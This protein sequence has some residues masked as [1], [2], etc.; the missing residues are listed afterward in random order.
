[1]WSSHG[2]SS[3]EAAQV[4]YSVRIIDRLHGV[5]T[6]LSLIERI[7]IFAVFSILLR[8][9]GQIT[10]DVDIRIQVN[11]S[12]SIASNVTS[13]EIKRKKACIRGTVPYQVQGNLCPLSGMIDIDSSTD[14]V[15]T[16]C[17]DKGREEG[18]IWM[19]LCKFAD[20]WSFW[21]VWP[22]YRILLIKKTRYINS[23]LFLK[24]FIVSWNGVL[25][26]WIFL[27]PRCEEHWTGQWAKKANNYITCFWNTFENVQGSWIFWGVIIEN[28]W[29]I[30]LPL[31]PHA[32]FRS[33]PSPTIHQIC[34][35]SFHPAIIV[36][37]VHLHIWKNLVSTASF[38]NLNIVHIYSVFVN[39]LLHYIYSSFHCLFFTSY[40]PL[41]P[42]HVFL[43][44]HTR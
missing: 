23:F 22:M 20:R 25:N 10:A 29:F 17:L 41:T 44:L 13:L 21:A 19:G 15:S 6:L 37:W 16:F 43:T 14:D 5:C 11:I 3:I 28:S 39:I 38:N 34:S 1:M 26:S 30:S 2:R 33:H 8:C 24:Y 31:Y 9:S 42:Y 36:V 7:P 35:S 27:I 40:I 32:V 12:V 4:N 18:Q